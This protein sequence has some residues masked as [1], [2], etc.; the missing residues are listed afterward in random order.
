[1][2]KKNGKPEVEKFQIEGDPTPYD[3]FVKVLRRASA[4]GP[5]AKVYRVNDGVLMA[6]IPTGKKMVEIE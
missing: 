5:G 2:G 4:I 6:I 3:D 1:V